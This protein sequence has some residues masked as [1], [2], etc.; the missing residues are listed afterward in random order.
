MQSWEA[1]HEYFQSRASEE[2]GLGAESWLGQLRKGLVSRMKTFNF[3]LS[4]V[5]SL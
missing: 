5:V 4:K 3:I 1:G 2:D